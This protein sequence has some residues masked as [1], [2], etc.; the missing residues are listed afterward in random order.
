MGIPIRQSNFKQ[1]LEFVQWE[2]MN[3]EKRA[4]QMLKAA[5]TPIEAARAI[6]YGYERSSHQHLGQR[7]ANAAALV[8]QNVSS[9][10]VSPV[11]PT[12][13]VINPTTTTTP[14][15]DAIK[16][17]SPTQETIPSATDPRTERIGKE[18]GHGPISGAAHEGHAEKTEGSAALPAGDIVALGHTLEKMGMRISEHPQFGG[19]NPVHKGKAHYEGRAIDI[20]VGKGV[21]EASD[22]VLGTKFD[23]LAEQLTKM[24]YKV[25]WRESG[26]YGAAGHN[27]HLHAELPRGG[28]TPVPDT[29]QIAGTPEQ[30]ALQGATPAVTGTSPISAAP[31]PIGTSV[32]AEPMSQ[33]PMTGITSPELGNIIPAQIM[34]MMGGGIGGIAGMLLPMIAS[35]IQSEMVSMPSMP[36]LNAQA[37]NQAAVSA[38]AAEQTIQE[39]QSSFYTPQVNPEANRMTMGDNSGFAYNMPDD[40]GWPDWA[41]MIGGNHWEEMKNY[42]KNMSWG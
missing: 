9:G 10:N 31:Q 40:I 35:T 23:R 18:G 14:T 41:G 12:S 4:G 3:S 42:K 27:N 11:T 32:A 39:A 34:G 6:D 22:P 33:P 2:L 21:T 20:N 30:R 38:Q 17:T 1:Q 37:V 7:M 25:Y 19:V 15:A 26:P 29:Y 36:A 8:K 24:G 13:P 5:S 16:V 28:S